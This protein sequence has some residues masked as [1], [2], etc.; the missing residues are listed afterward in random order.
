MS[1]PDL[2]HILIN[3]DHFPLDKA[4]LCEDCQEVHRNSEQCPACASRNIMGLA[5]I[6]NRDTDPGEQEEKCRK[7]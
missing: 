4:F 1:T 7:D 5:R 2:S 3:S 6:L